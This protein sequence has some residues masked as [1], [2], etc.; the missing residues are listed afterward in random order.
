MLQVNT[1]DVLSNPERIGSM[2]LQDMNTKNDKFAVI[3]EAGGVVT[4]GD[5]WGD[6][7]VSPKKLVLVS[8]KYSRAT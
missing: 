6:R 7:V 5:F 4:W 2:A 3:T 8:P 1:Q